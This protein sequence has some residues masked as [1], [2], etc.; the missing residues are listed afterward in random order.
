[1]DN[2]ALDTEPPVAS[3]M[4]SMLI[5]GGPVNAVVEL[6]RTYSS[7]AS[8]FLRGRGSWLP[9]NCINAMPCSSSLAASDSLAAT[10]V[11]RRTVHCAVLG[12][13]MVLDRLRQLTFCH[14]FYLLPWARRT[15]DRLT[16]VT[17]VTSNFLSPL[18]IK[19]IVSLAL[20]M[21]AALLESCRV[22]LLSFSIS[23]KHREST[24]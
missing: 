18:S 11:A 6:N 13:S 1:M 8:R 4:T 24:S 21:I 14:S 3:F 9:A 15:S 19:P 7:V 22:R 17:V 12:L 20:F 2:Q 23:L 16:I 5:G 10:L